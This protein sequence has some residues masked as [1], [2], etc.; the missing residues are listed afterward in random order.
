MKKYR[1][2]LVLGFPK[3][4]KQIDYD[5]LTNEAIVNFIS[6]GKIIK[7]Y[8]ITCIPIGIGNFRMAVKSF[9]K[10]S[11]FR[12]KNF[13]WSDKPPQV[14]VTFINTIRLSKTIKIYGALICYEREHH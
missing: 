13:V 5:L 9:A 6:N 4:I 14:R 1:F 11:K 10:D 2:S 7:K 8:P 3:N 12:L